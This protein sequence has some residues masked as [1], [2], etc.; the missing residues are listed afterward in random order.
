MAELK[1]KLTLNLPQDLKEK[2][3]NDPS[4]LQRLITLVTRAYEANK[5]DKWLS[6]VLYKEEALRKDKEFR[7]L[8]PEFNSRLNDNY[9]LEP[10]KYGGIDLG[11]RMSYSIGSNPKRYI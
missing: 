7:K 4:E 2:T 3:I 8:H 1:I 6:D 9:G 11:K 10:Q 5:S